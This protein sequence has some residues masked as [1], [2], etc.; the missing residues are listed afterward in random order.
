SQR[1]RTAQEATQF[2]RPDFAGFTQQSLARQHNLQLQAATNRRAREAAAKQEALME[3]LRQA[4]E[5]KRVQ[6]DA[7]KNDPRKYKYQPPTV[8]PGS[9]VPGGGGSHKVVGTGRGGV[10]LVGPYKLTQNTYNAYLA[11]NQAYNQKW[12]TN[13]QIN[14]GGRTYAE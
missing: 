13:L 10:P 12:G 9:Y 2:S 5:S 7:P 11:L 1:G 8:T 6:F 4:A 3:Q 14:S